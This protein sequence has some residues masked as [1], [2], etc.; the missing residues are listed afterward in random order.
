MR[1][2]RCFIK[3]NNGYFYWQAIALWRDATSDEKH[4]KVHGLNS[5]S[6]V[7]NP[8]VSEPLLVSSNF[9][10]DRVNKNEIRGT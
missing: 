9:L 2:H 8:E 6:I 10:E 7:K 3:R 5:S 4:G 1:S